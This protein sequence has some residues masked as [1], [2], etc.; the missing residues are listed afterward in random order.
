MVV[1]FIIIL[2]VNSLSVKLVAKSP[3]TSHY[4]RT[5]LYAGAPYFVSTEKISYFKKNINFS[6]Q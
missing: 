3:W 4:H 1:E 2:Y 5:I 6:Y